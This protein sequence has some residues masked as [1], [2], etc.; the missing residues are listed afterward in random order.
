M[1]NINKFNDQFSG[2]KMHFQDYEL[3]VFETLSIAKNL[4]FYWNDGYTKSFL[5][6]INK[7]IQF[8]ND[9][10]NSIYDLCSL[11]AYAIMLYNDINSKQGELLGI[12]SNI[13]NTN[14]FIVQSN[15]DNETA[16]KKSYLYNKTID[17]ED[18]IS[19]DIF[20]LNIPYIKR[21]NFDDLSAESPEKGFIGM[22]DGIDNEIN[23]LHI[24]IQDTVKATNLLKENLY[25]I[26]VYYNSTNSNK[27]KKIVEDLEKEF[28]TLN[29]N[30]ENVFEYIYS[31]KNDYS[32]LF[33]ELANETKIYFDN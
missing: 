14:D 12:Y 29:V 4:S 5:S 25:E 15:D 20:K 19:S 3:K 1:I 31:R 27:L 6:E 33:E 24:S 13:V 2:V 7:E 21:I 22:L 32:K 26:L 30:L 23:K 17:I 16:T 11:F 10:I 8:T 9:L 18:K 28:N